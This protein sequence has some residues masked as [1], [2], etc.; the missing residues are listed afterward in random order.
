MTK[1][2][3]ALALIVIVLIIAGYV[4]RY[5]IRDIIDGIR[6]VTPQQRA[7]IELID[8]NP[9]QKEI[10]KDPAS[11]ATRAL[12]YARDAAVATTTVY[13][14]NC[15]P[16]PV[17]AQVKYGETVLLKNQSLA[18]TTITYVGI[19]NT[20]A[21]LAEIKIKSVDILKNQRVDAF[22]AIGYMCGSSTRPVGYIYITN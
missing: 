18:T 11:V 21:P 5:Q 8:L 10:A 15:V 3:K 19:H 4:Y 13:I 17:I 14:N 9:S 2:T 22:T 1:S 20:F 7:Q 12:T 6:G 16:S